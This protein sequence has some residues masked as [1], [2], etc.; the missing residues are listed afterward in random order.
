MEVS[1]INPALSHE[2]GLAEETGVVVTGDTSQNRFF[3]VAHTGDIIVAINGEKITS[4]QNLQDILK[5]MS[6]EGRNAWQFAMSRNGQIRQ[7]VV[8]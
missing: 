5:K 1:N 2:L 6:S 3:S 7:V 8:R 4:V